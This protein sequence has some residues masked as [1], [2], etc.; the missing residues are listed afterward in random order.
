[1]DRTIYDVAHEAG[2]SISTVSRA[3][4]NT[5]YVSE[6]TRAKIEAAMNGFYPNAAAKAMMTKRSNVIGV[7]SFL[8]PKRFFLSGTLSNSLA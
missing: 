7:V 8:S 1:M 4:N 3:L 5:G 6:K 2:V